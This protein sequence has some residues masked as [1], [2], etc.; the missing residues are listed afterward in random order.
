MGIEFDSGISWYMY[1]MKR[2]MGIFF[3][4]ESLETGCKIWTHLQRSKYCLFR[5]TH[6]V[7]SNKGP[8][9]LDWLL[10]IMRD[11]GKNK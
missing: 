9:L 4:L 3:F 6:E 2:E 5:Y 11:M 8:D 1:N 7:N 10:F